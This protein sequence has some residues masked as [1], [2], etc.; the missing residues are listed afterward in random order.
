MPSTVTKS[1]TTFAGP[2]T[3]TGW[4]P[5][6]AAI[7]NAST[8]PA[9]GTATKAVLTLDNWVN[10]S[11][12]PFEFTI[13]NMGIPQAATLLGF[14]VRIYGH[15]IGTAGQIYTGGNIDGDGTI[16]LT[17]GVYDINGFEGFYN[18]IGTD[19]SHI[20][21]FPE[22]SGNVLPMEYIEIGGPTDL[23]GLSASALKAQLN[24]NSGSG[25]LKLLIDYG[26]Y[27]GG[28]QDLREAS[29]PTATATKLLTGMW[30]NDPTT[31]IPANTLANVGGSGW[32]TKAVQSFTASEQRFGGLKCDFGS[33]ALA[34]DLTVTGIEVRAYGQSI[35]ST[36]GR[37][38]VNGT[39]GGS[40]TVEH[41]GQLG[42]TK[43]SA[44]SYANMM[45]DG[46]GFTRRQHVDLFTNSS[47]NITTAKVL[48]FGG[49]GDMLDM[50]SA[51]IKAALLANSGANKI[52]F[53]IDDG[54]FWR[55]TANVTRELAAVVLVIYGHGPGDSTVREIAAVECTAFYS[56]VSLAATCQDVCS[57]IYAVYKATQ[58]KHSI[59][60][61]VP[62]DREPNK[63]AVS[64]PAASGGNTTIYENQF[65]HEVDIS[66]YVAMQRSAR[67]LADKL[68]DYQ[69]NS[70]DCTGLSSALGIREID[71]PT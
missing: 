61:Y 28:S 66:S 4:N 57:R 55:D 36:A 10:P 51:E 29:Y 32:S 17:Q 24:D 37:V 35:G 2:D 39:S 9:F 70:L 56:N 50:T 46:D 59:R 33:I 34:S 67:V 12:N 52:G 27:T 3:A 68:N 53:L 45:T 58:S 20:D 71:P 25:I 8:P 11:L 1:V 43:G 63:W 31:I 18:I 44:I 5:A 64:D 41:A 16:G 40:K 54:L 23:F 65:H 21:A 48:L 6:L 38:T 19:K 30:T 14:R 49:A 42:I 60:L 47:G 15:R 69:A 13:P 26:A 62:D 7:A 22:G